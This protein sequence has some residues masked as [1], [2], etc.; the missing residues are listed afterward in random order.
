MELAHLI[1]EARKSHSLS[2]AVWRLR[3][4]GGVVLIH[5]QRTENKEC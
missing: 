3:E 5:V 2:P 4:A 1:M